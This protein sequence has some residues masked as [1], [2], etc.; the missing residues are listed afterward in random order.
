MD[1]L[2]QPMRIA[3][4]DVAAAQRQRLAG[5]LQFEHVFVEPQPGTAGAQPVDA[6][7]ALRFAAPQAQLFQPRL[8]HLPGAG[9][10][11]VDKSCL[12]PGSVI[13][14]VFEHETP[15]AEYVLAAMLEHAMGYGRLRQQFRADR[16]QETY[17]ARGTHAELYGKTLGLIGYGHIGRAVADRARPFGM[18]VH[19][20]SNS[21]NAPGSHWCATPDKLDELLKKAD[22]V[23]I[24]CPLTPATRGMIGERQLA[25]MKTSAVLINI[26][27]AQIVEEKP[28]YEALFQ[29]RLAGATLDVWYAYPSSESPR[30]QPAQYPFWELPNVHCTAH[31][32]ALTEEL[33]ERRYA[34]IA[35]NL[36]RLRRGEPLSNV[37]FTTSQP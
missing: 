8:L 29:G 18:K 7:I 10:D 16:W 32:S 23:V 15:L 4:L 28:L 13:C 11:A 20:I 27:R 26:S 35:A 1:S 12:P 14:N 31:T 30:V 6:V 9:D 3:M 2:S 5:L 33:Y 17:A 34:V 21:G 37:I 36:G 25:V 19:A 24:A 22:Y